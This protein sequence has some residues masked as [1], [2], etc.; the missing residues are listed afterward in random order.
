M[1][2]NDGE[3]NGQAQDQ[4]TYNLRRLGTPY[5]GWEFL[6]V[7]QLHNATIISAGLGEDASFD[8]EFAKAYNATVVIVDPTPRAVLHFSGIQQRLG[9]PRSELY[10]EGGKQP[11]GAYDLTGLSD[12]NFI[13]VPNALWN[14]ATTLKFYQPTNPEFV[15][16]SIINFQNEYRTDTPSI[17]VEAL[18][19]SGLLEKAGLNG[20]EIPLLKM[21][22]EGAEI[23][24]IE[25]LLVA[26]HRPR[27]ILVEFDELNTKAQRGV[28]RFTHIN[29]VLDAH[30]YRALKRLSFSD[31]L[32]G[33]VA[34]FV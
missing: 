18:T 20:R 25:D 31:F 7:G 32:Y 30:G 23:E 22:I 19:F 3:A 17:E 2:S 28:D 33:H 5:G 26:G 9:Q 8:V 24:V 14:Q 12:D 11:A 10:V 4:K 6:D 15:S 1:D 34:T 13:F 29:G 21:D 16:H 27:Q